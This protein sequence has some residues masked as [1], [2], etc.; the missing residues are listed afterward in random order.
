CSCIG[1]LA[2]VSYGSNYCG[3]DQW[4]YHHAQQLDIS[5]SDA[6]EE[7]AKPLQTHARGNETSNKSDNK[8]G[9]N[10]CAEARCPSG[11]TGPLLLVCFR[12]SCRIRHAQYL[13]SLHF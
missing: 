7:I 2:Q 9:E 11:Q 4:W 1:D 12:A 6:A 5:I 13:S 8:A 3:E 10:L